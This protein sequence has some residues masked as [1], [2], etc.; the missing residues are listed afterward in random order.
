METRADFN[1]EVARLAYVNL[2]TVE[3]MKLVDIV[4]EIILP[5]IALIGGAQNRNPRISDTFMNFM[6][7][8]GHFIH[9][10]VTDKWKTVLF[11]IALQRLSKGALLHTPV[12]LIEILPEE[13]KMYTAAYDEPG[14]FN[15]ACW[16]FLSTNIPILFNNIGGV[17]QGHAHKI[18]FGIMQYISEDGKTCMP[19][20]EEDAGITPLELR[21]LVE[22]YAKDWCS[23]EERWNYVMEAKNDK[24]YLWVKECNA[25]G[26]PYLKLTK[27]LAPF[28]SKNKAFFKDNFEVISWDVF[29]QHVDFDKE[30]F[31]VGWKKKFLKC[32]GLY[33]D[34]T[35]SKIKAEIKA[36]KG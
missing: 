34:L 33:K 28:W 8:Y 30:K 31:Y 9:F 21:Q 35:V 19:F 17:V 18:V 10:N 13:Y 29:C 23:E 24:A 12:N 25:G 3:K 26:I 36:Y 27:S 6:A 1:Q 5:R 32:L 7:D 4:D 22:E 16:N 14:I 20:N 15:K 11:E 2:A